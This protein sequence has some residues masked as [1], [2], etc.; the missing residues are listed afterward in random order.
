MTE[1]I[2]QDDGPQPIGLHQNRIAMDFGQALNRLQNGEKVTRAGWNGPNQ[3]LSLQRPDENSKMTLPYIYI[4][5]VQHD[6]VPWFA[7]QTDMLA[8]D[9]WVSQ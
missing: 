4:T 1:G 8:Q 3:Y 2:V 6:L 7:S 9:W 5:T